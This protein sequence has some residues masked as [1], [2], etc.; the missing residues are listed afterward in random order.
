[1]SV[2]QR[3]SIQLKVTL[4]VALAVLLTVLSAAHIYR[5]LDGQSARLA[6]IAGLSR[7]ASERVL[8]LNRRIADI[9]FHTVQVQQFFTDLAATRGEDGLDDGPKEAARHRK[10]AQDSLVMARGLA[11]ELGLASTVKALDDL[12]GR[13]TAYF[14]GGQRMAEAYVKQGTTAG[15]VLMKA[16]DIEASAMA[17][18]LT[19]LFSLVEEASAQRTARL[20]AAVDDINRSNTAI[21]ALFGT[22]AV[23]VLVA[24]GFAILLFKGLVIRPLERLEVVTTHLAGGQT[25]ETIPYLARSDEIG[26]IAR[27]IRTFQDN[28]HDNERLRTEQRKLERAVAAEKNQSLLV[29]AETVERETRSAVDD[30]AEHTAAMVQNADAMAS[31]AALVSGNSN[32]V[33][34]AAMTALENAQTVASA[35]EELSASIRSINAQVNLSSDVVARAVSKNVA[36]RGTIETLASTVGRID[37]MARLIAG[38]ASQTNLLALN[39]TIEAAR[40]GEADKGF[41]V[42]AGEVK[43]L[44]AQTSRSTEEITRQVQE[45][46]SVTRAAVEAVTEIGTLIEEINVVSGSIAAAMEEQSAATREIAQNV[47]QTATAAH[48]VS[49]RIAEVSQEAHATGDHAHGVR[50]TAGS[51]AHSINALREVLV[52]V[53]RTSA[54]EVD[55]R[56]DTRYRLETSCQVK[57]PGG[58]YTVHSRNVS[59]GGAMVA[60]AGLPALE[61]GSLGS[62]RIDGIRTALS[63]EVMDSSTGR[64]HVRF[65]LNED[66]RE[67]YLQDFVRITRNLEVL[68]SSDSAMA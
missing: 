57:V 66:N 15:N 7:V 2:I 5:A 45:I 48:E 38:I 11:E 55:R 19:A 10:I 6:E 1:M 50:Q 49:A 56:R 16:F 13:Q 39:A 30:V 44:A 14:E 24:G 60:G 64:L 12:Q 18:R 8:A 61:V 31:S 37:D 20:A 26:R 36:A 43:N 22:L 62:M 52:R 34:S 51:V 63:F 32:S 33:A 28:A 58:E 35:A 47:G 59:V 3:L 42:V 68:P 53:V 21:I 46:Q 23:V 29:M 40:A 9:R 67:S 65:G 17:D 54:K 25:D 4:V 41:A 27:A